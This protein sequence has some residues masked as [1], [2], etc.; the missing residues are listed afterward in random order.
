MYLASLA[1]I[2]RGKFIWIYFSCLGLLLTSQKLS[3]VVIP[4]FNFTEYLKSI[5]KYKITHLL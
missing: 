3:L 4:K 1:I 5:D 2:L